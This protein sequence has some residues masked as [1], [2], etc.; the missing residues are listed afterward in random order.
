V[1]SV[2]EAV[3]VAESARVVN[4]VLMRDTLQAEAAWLQ[5][6]HRPEEAR[7]VRAKAKALAQTAAQNTDASYLVDARDLR[8]NPA[9]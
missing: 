9:D 2:E 5:K 6:L 3:R 7:Q 4:P 8:K 1:R